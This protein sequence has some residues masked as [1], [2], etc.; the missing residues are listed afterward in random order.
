MAEDRGWQIVGVY[1][2]LDRRFPQPVKFQRR[3]LRSPPILPRIVEEPVLDVERLSVR[4]RSGRPDR[5][6]AIRAVPCLWI[7][8]ACAAC[9]TAPHG[10]LT[11]E[12]AAQALSE[13]V[14]TGVENITLVTPRGCFT[15]PIETPIDRIDPRRE[16]GI[17]DRRN[18]ALR[19]L[20]D[21]ELVEFELQEAPVSSPTPVAGCEQIWLRHAESA[22]GGASAQVKLISWTTM[23]SDKGRVAGFQP[24]QRF[25]YRRQTLVDV[26]EPIAVKGDT[27]T[28]SYRWQW[29]PTEDGAHLGVRA[30][31][32]VRASATFTRSAGRWQLR[33]P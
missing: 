3:V 2:P 19:Q 12:Y 28:V 4:V 27:A 5:R 20:V 29:A 22:I 10:E 31:D 1:G 24:G 18:D 25:L 26:E 11:R 30:G 9:Q 32:A 7:A 13:S 14:L 17:Y 23:L 15:V 33:L 16:P 8:A 21:L 6:V